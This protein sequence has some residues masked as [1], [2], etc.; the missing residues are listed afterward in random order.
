MGS[1][2]VPCSGA[3]AAL[4]RR[5]HVTDRLEGRNLFVGDLDVE[6]LFQLHQ[7]LEN[8]EDAAR[9]FNHYLRMRADPGPVLQ[10]DVQEVR[11]RLAEVESRLAGT[12]AAR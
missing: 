11:D 1:G 3:D 4:D 12:T 8:W 10:A 2:P 9:A 5:Q 6:A 7:E